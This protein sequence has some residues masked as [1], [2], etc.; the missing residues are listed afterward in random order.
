MEAAEAPLLAGVWSAQD[1]TPSEIDA[2]LRRLHEEQNAKT[3]GG[4]APARVLNLAVVLDREWRGEIVNRL[5]RVGRYH[6]SRTIVCAFQEGRDTLD[7]WAMIGCEEFE[8]GSLAVC[9]ERVEIDVGPR[10]LPHLDAIVD[11]LLVPDLSTVVWSPHGH[12][13]AVDSLLHLA[14][15]VLID[16]VEEP[17]PRSAIERAHRLAEGAYVVDLAWLRSTPWRE[18]I[19]AMFDPPARRPALRQVIGVTVRH[20]PDSTESALLLLGWLGSRLGWDPGS[21]MTHDGGLQGRAR[22]GKYELQ[23]RLE[24]DATM[25]VPGLAG[26]TLDTSGG[27]SLSL[28]RGPG[29]LTAVRR[30]G[31]GREFAWTVLGASRGEAG[32]LGEGIRQALLRDPT[33]RPALDWASATLA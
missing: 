21:L 10:H 26:V 3:E 2:A 14:H 9:T 18:R 16:S 27:L 33:Y 19:A 8:P 6:P 4:Y 5:E 20:Q 15:A 23:L 30:S 25:S 1:T 28:N 13:D 29:G 31:D 22:C 32:I 7:A 17:E 12:A 11:P 24:V